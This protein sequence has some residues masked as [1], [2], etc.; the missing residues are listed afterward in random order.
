MSN[1]NSNGNGSKKSEPILTLVEDIKEHKVTKENS[2]SWDLKA[3]PTVDGS[4]TY[5]QSVRILSGH[6]TVRQI[7]RWG[8]DVVKVLVGLN[9]TTVTTQRPIYRA[10]MRE[11]PWATLNKS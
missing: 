4:A 7:L 5:K 6:E 9:L 11:T 2:V 10:L 1:N 8:K 3:Q